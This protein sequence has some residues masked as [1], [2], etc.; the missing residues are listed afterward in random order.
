MPSRSTGSWAAP[1]SF[2]PTRCQVP[3]RSTCADAGAADSETAATESA[4]IH[5]YFVMASPGCRTGCRIP[6]AAVAF[7]FEHRRRQSGVG[8]ELRIVDLSRDGE[9]LLTIR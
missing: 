8:Q 5:M 1:L 2:C 3:V 6:F 7:L 4:H 9:P